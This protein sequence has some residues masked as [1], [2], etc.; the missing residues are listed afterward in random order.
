MASNVSNAICTAAID[1]AIDHVRLFLFG[2]AA[3]VQVI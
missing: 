3:I 2:T 1:R